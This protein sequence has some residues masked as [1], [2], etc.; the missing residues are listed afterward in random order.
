MKYGRAKLNNVINLMSVLKWKK[1]INVK[2][3]RR[4]NSGSKARWKGEEREK[5]GIPMFHIERK[6]FMFLLVR[7]CTLPLSGKE[8]GSVT[9]S[10]LFHL[11]LSFFLPFRDLFFPFLPYASPLLFS[12]YYLTHLFGTLVYIREVVHLHPRAPDRV[13]FAWATY[14]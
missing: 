12:C 3:T 2:R 8:N 13:Q 9:S 4:N 1:I 6:N 5:E 14:P 7:F 10:R 11:M